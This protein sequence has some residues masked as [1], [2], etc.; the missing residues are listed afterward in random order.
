MGNKQALQPL[1]VFCTCPSKKRL[2]FHRKCCIPLFSPT[3]GETHI[4]PFLFNP[5]P[6]RLFTLSYWAVPTYCL[7]RFSYSTTSVG[8]KEKIN[9]RGK[10]FAEALEKRKFCFILRRNYENTTILLCVSDAKLYQGNSA[11]HAHE[12]IKWHFLP[13]LLLASP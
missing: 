10:T 9:I 3:P 5:G 6:T 1:S 8:F 11:Q 2:V 4:T 7:K 12:Q 13:N